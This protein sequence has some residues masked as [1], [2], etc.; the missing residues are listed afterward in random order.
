MT[1]PRYQ[2]QPTTAEIAAAAGI[3]P[4]DVIRFD[5]NTS[6]FPSPWAVDVAAPTAAALNEYPGASYVPLRIAAAASTG[7]GA[8]NVV[9]GAG[10]DELILLAARAFLAP[11]A[12]AVATSPTYTL[13]RI[14]TMQ[15]GAEYVE[16]PR[17]PDLEFP[18]EMLVDAARDSDLTWLCVPDNPI[19]DR[20]GDDT[21]AAVVNAT[22]GVV[23]LD[24]AYAEFSG[25]RWGPWVERHHNLLV[26]HTMSKAH[27][28]AAVRVGYALGHPSLIDALDGVRPPGSISTL[29]S[30]LAI[31]ALG[32]PE[33]AE[34]TV[35]ALG[36]GREALAPRLA[37]L[38]FRV[39]PSVTNFL[40][41]EV[42]P[43]A[44]RLAEA[45]MAEGLVI[46][47]FPVGGLLEHH[48]RFTI[49]DTAAHDRLVDSLRRAL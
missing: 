26:L 27:G 32:R 42:G 13:Y 45:L 39:I 30:D 18:A 28:L 25:D 9:P 4:G 20:I 3:A 14:A 16:V 48:L 23:V 35:E 33:L 17:D 38:G 44:K 12:S 21:I 22:D 1:V 2:W 19:G 37:D 47:T 11:G 49:R 8:E 6:P 31:A 15:V 40:L 36:A 43:E 5:H 34:R 29:S 7:V 41:C 46:R 24:A 10:A